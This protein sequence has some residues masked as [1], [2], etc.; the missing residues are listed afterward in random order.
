MES[1]LSIISFEK[2][3]VSPFINMRLTVFPESLWPAISSVSPDEKCTV[4]ERVGA[5][6]EVAKNI[7]RETTHASPKMARDMCRNLAYCIV[8][9]QPALCF[10]FGRMA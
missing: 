9:H 7:E 2:F 10:C 5:S 6:P 1:M 3:T 4:S 8:L